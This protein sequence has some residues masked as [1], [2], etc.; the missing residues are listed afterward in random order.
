M[1]IFFG[2]LRNRRQSHGVG[3]ASAKELAPVSGLVRLILGRQENRRRASIRLGDNSKPLA[4]SGA[5][6]AQ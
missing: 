1:K 5:V 3:G 2:G 4:L 6:V